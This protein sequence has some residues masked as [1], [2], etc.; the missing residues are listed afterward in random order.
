MSRI[1]SYLGE[2][3]NP[4]LFL[5]YDN[6]SAAPIRINNLYSLNFENFTSIEP[7]T[8][9]KTIPV[10]YLYMYS[11]ATRNNK[12]YI[13]RNTFN[14]QSK[15]YKTILPYLKLFVDT[16]YPSDMYFINIGNNQYY[17]KKGLILNKNKKPIISVVVEVV[18][19]H[20]DYYRL[21]IIE[22]KVLIDYSVFESNG[23]CEKAI[24]SVLIPIIMNYR[25]KVEI[26]NLTDVDLFEHPVMPKSI[27]KSRDLVYDI[28][29][30][31]FGIL[32]KEFL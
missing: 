27:E 11:L 14:S 21:N 25:Y 3:L 23:S 1:A 19:S 16:N 28:L 4:S 32:T 5:N 29:R 6:L 8:E 18:P 30:N 10:S 13:F 7:I 31:N 15:K 17:I 9:S 26:C 12:N 22:P 20:T 2:R 24:K